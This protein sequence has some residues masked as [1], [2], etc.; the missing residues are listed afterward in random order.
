MTASSPFVARRIADA[1]ARYGFESLVA[2]SDAEASCD[3]EI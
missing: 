1:L 3:G 2:E